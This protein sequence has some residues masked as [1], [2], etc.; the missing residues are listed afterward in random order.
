M[1]ICGFLLVQFT[2]SVNCAKFWLSA[3]F[4]DFAII[5]SIAAIARGKTYIPSIIPSRFMTAMFDYRS[6][7]I[8]LVLSFIKFQSAWVD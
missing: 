3:S 5:L 4:Y 2:F 8:P 6:I 1:F 7:S